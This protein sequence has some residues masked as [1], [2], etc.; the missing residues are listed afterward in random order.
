MRDVQN[1]NELMD[2]NSHFTCTSTEGMRTVLQ[3]AFKEAG[4]TVR[5]FA[6]LPLA[7][8]VFSDDAV[9][10]LKNFLK[11]PTHSLKLVIGSDVWERNDPLNA[12]IKNI[13]DLFRSQVSL[14]FADSKHRVIGSIMT[15]DTGK[16]S[17]FG[18][19]VS[20]NCQAT[21]RNMSKNFDR[22]YKTADS[23]LPAPIHALSLQNPTQS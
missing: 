18:D 15:T 10:D 9:A 5:I 20:F 6:D 7:E 3:R 1:F 21:A 14:K 2:K 16:M 11:D 19:I 17:L 12:N 23:E 8:R 22:L 13:T 4:D